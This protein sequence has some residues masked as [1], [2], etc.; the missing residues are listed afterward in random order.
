MISVGLGSSYYDSGST[1]HSNLAWYGGA[2]FYSEATSGL[3]GTHFHNN[4][5]FEGGA[6]SA[7]EFTN[8]ERFEDVKVYSNHATGTAA[9]INLK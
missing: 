5:A 4:Y 1:F 9:G 7:E 2:I 6:I 8:I 3:V